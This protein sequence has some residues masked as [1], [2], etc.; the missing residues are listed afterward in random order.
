MP[1]IRKIL[2]V[3]GLNNTEPDQK[4]EI[5]SEFKILSYKTEK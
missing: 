5:L 1:L 4:S 2:M 3:V